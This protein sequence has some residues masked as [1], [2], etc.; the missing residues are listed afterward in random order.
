METKQINEA[1]EKKV[2]LEVVSNQIC[3]NRTEISKL[4]MVLWE[5]IANNG[6]VFCWADSEEEAYESFGY[7]KNSNVRHTVVEINP[8]S[9]PVTDGREAN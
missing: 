1:E 8:E 3:G 9:M 6:I 2:N 4:Y 5:R 7:S